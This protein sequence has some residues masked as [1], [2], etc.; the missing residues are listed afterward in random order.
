MIFGLVFF[1][2]GAITDSL[3]GYLAR[4]FKTTSRAGRIIDP[5]ADKVLVFSALATLVLGDVIFLW[6]AIVIAL[7]DITV[8]TLRMLDLKNEA[9]VSPNIF[10]KIK[11]SYLMIIIG[12]LLLLPIIGVVPD[13]SIT[14]YP[15]ILMM[16]AM[17][18]AWGSSI[19]YLLGFLKKKQSQENH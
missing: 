10:A 4:K 7:R 19:P 2:I 16:L 11:T 8:T 5:I 13:R 17:I 9:V 6:I 1:V 14:S 15:N 3:D 12:F 18:A